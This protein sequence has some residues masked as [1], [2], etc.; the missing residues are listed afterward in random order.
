MDAEEANGAIKN[1][2][3][4]GKDILIEEFWR[5][6]GNGVAFWDSCGVR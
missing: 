3:G 2:G 6:T 5:P 4:A 1:P